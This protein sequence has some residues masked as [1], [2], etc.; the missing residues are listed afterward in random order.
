V[1]ALDLLASRLPANSFGVVFMGD[2]GAPPSTMGDGLLC[3]G[4]PLV[5]HFP[6][7]MTDGSG[8]LAELDVSG[9]SAG[10]H[11][12]ARIVIGST[13]HFQCAYRD[14]GGPCG[15]GFNVTNGLQVT[16]LR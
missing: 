13:W 3:V 1:C 14:P 11:P 8:R 4:G 6:P 10:F 9:T 5:Q 12:S 16:F 2:A 15:S 7:R